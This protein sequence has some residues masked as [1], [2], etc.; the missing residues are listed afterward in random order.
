V[1]GSG[2]SFVVVAAGY[3]Y[4][5]YVTDADLSILDRS[6]KRTDIDVRAIEVSQRRAAF[7]AVAAEADAVVIA[8]WGGQGLEAIPDWLDAAPRA[9]V[10]A[11]TFDF[12]FDQISAHDIFRADRSVTVIDT[13]RTLTPTVAEFCL[14]MI[15][16]LLREVPDQIGLV[17]AGGW[18]QEWRDVRGFVGGDLAGRSVGLAG[19][20][21]INRTL[22][23]LLAPF[24]CQVSAFDPHVPAQE[25]AAAGVRAVADLVDLAETS[26][27]FVV[28]IPELPT[29]T[30]IID[31][32][33]IDALPAGALFV[34]PTRMAVVDQ[35][36]LRDRVLAGQLRAA[37]DVYSPEP[38][39]ADSWL[40]THP[41][42]LPT[43]H[44]AGN[45]AQGHRRCF[46]IAC[47]E[48]V[49]ALAGRPL[50]HAVTE[51]DAVRY[52]WRSARDGGG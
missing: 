40:R 26:E 34:L 51:A 11:G 49:A 1:S 23:R 12:R 50:R 18:T 46:R 10:V 9:S 20:G 25:M 35:S 44:L 39:P 45:T 36:A 8:P 7:A 22:A 27:I 6:G 31:R 43:P 17:R 16:N 21:V 3:K 32:S 42:V 4:G 24:E 30:G 47:A 5:T 38:P 37:V 15:L 2:P 33:V 29:T 41:D 19:Y 52:G 13:S 48:A 14:G 28:G